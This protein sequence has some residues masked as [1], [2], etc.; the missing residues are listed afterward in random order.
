[1]APFGHPMRAVRR[2]CPHR[3]PLSAAG[4]NQSQ[5]PGS[6]EA[7]PGWSRLLDLWKVPSYGKPRKTVRRPS[8]AQ[9]TF[10]WRTVSLSFP[11]DLEI[12]CADSHTSHRP[13]D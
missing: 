9:Q 7:A 6:G 2:A 5:P 1:M 10:E 13:G 4:C 8:V 3:G 11:Q 12:G